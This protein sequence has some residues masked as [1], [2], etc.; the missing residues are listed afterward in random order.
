[1]IAP[2]RTDKKTPASRRIHAA[3]AMIAAMLLPNEPAAPPIAAWKAWLFVAWVGMT[4]L[5]YTFSM[6]E[7]ILQGAG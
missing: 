6:A 5:A 2:L 4:L 1:M 7:L 3:R